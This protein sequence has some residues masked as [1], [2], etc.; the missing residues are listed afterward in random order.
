[1][2]SDGVLAELS[3]TQLFKIIGGDFE[4]ALKKNEESHEKKI[5]NLPQRADASHI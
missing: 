1:M 4:T 3:F 2:L 5:A